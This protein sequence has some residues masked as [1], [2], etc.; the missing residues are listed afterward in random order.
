MLP[1]APFAEA[2]A[3]YVAHADQQLLRNHVQAHGAELGRLVPDALHS[4]WSFGADPLRRPTLTPNATSCLARSW[5]CW[6]RPAPS[7]V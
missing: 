7:V 2:S 3:H 6:T 4:A 5:H 1:Y